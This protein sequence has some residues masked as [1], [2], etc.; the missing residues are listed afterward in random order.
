MT[1]SEY[2]QDTSSPATPPLARIV[3]V[4]DEA[5]VLGVLRDLL[6]NAGYEVHCFLEGGKALAYLKENQG[7][8]DLILTDQKMPGISGVDLLRQAHAEDPAV[9]GLLMT[10][11]STLENAVEAFRAGAFDFISKPTHLDSLGISLNRA[12]QHR[13][14]LV[15]NLLYQDKMARLVEERGEQ[16]KEM[17]KHLEFSYQFMLESLVSL[18]EAREPLTGEHTKRV[19]GMAVALA[20]RMGIEGEALEV[21]RRGASL[22]DVGKIAI[23]DAI[24]L[25]D[26]PLSPE[27]WE[28]MKTHVEI[29]YSILRSN[30]YMRE[31]AE[32]VHS[33]HENFDGSG[34]PRGLK[35]E[36]ICLGARIFSVVD[37]YDAIRSTRTYS[38]VHSPEAVVREIRRCAGSQFDPEVVRA[39]VANQQA[40]EEV[41]WQGATE[42][43]RCARFD[44][45]GKEVSP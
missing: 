45:E 26:G 24:L 28:I 43:D 31:V 12:L 42:R 18:L 27:E 29:G 4:D 17:T 37:A 32:L 9:V 10:G 21:I 16:L 8:T 33:H 38:G 13:R 6:E 44:G 20:T 11:Y 7:W 30:S 14:V 2:L 23:P 19:T 22:H 41:W 39:L 36:E 3:L 5:S 34:Y 40:I 25:K 1:S 15:E 35:G